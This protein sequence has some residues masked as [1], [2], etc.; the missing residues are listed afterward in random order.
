MKKKIEIE[1]NYD[2]YKSLAEFVVDRLQSGKVLTCQDLMDFH[3][4]RLADKFDAKLC[5]S[6]PYI[7]PD[8][9]KPG[10]TFTKDDLPF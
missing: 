9:A 1:C 5:D 4:K 7:K 2:L 6:V 10:D 8:Q 3:V